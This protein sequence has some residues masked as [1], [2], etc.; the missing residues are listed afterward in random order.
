MKMLNNLNIF[1]QTRFQ[2]FHTHSVFVSSSMSNFQLYALPS[3]SSSLSIPYQHPT[4]I[5]YIWLNL[6]NICA[7]HYLN[8]KTNTRARCR[9]YS[10]IWI[11]LLLTNDLQ[12]SFQLQP[13]S[14]NNLSTSSAGWPPHSRHLFTNHSVPSGCLTLFIRVSGLP[15]FS[16]V[17]SNLMS[18]I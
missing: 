11:R 7:L 17:S 5:D 4:L 10:R 18:F 9:K 1:H 14:S 15:H 6:S 3:S 2:V 8:R 16:H 12:I 13:F